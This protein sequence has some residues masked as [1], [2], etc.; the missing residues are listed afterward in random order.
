MVLARPFSDHAD[1]SGMG[2]KRRRMI[3][4]RVDPQITRISQI[5]KLDKA[6]ERRDRSKLGLISGRA[7]YNH[8]QV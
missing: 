6:G 4:W 7:R 5:H 1:F 8:G 2:E 3:A